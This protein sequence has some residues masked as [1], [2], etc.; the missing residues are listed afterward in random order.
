MHVCQHTWRN[1]TPTKTATYIRF[2]R[3]Q[4]EHVRRKVVVVDD[5][6]DVTH[7]HLRPLDSLKG[8]ALEDSDFAAVDVC[9][10]AVTLLHAC[11]RE[12]LAGL[13]PHAWAAAGFC[14]ISNLQ[15]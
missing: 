9:I 13:Q 2:R 3:G 6:D 11:K 10:R 1:P 15:S 12:G 14:N 8:H 7:P 5:L 4:E